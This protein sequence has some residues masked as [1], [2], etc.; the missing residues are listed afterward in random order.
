MNEKAGEME[1]KVVEI[2]KKESKIKVLRVL[3]DE[4]KQWADMARDEFGD[5]LDW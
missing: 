2:T 1:D 4:E 3:T 5:K